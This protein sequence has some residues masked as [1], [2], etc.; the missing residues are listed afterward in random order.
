MGNLALI[1]TAIISFTSAE[2]SQT[3][4]DPS[5]HVLGEETTDLSSYQ[6]I[7]NAARLLVLAGIAVLVINT[8]LGSTKKKPTRQQRNQ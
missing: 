3:A 7:L 1:A 2:E 6:N 5:I 4:E 8:V